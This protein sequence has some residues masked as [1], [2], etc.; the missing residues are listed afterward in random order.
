MTA[1]DTAAPHAMPPTDPRRLIAVAGLAVLLSELVFLGGAYF[2]GFFLA[3][4]AGH[5]IANDFVNVWAAG[6]PRARWSRRASL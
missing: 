4:R 2:Q 5:G 6:P 3:D 1:F